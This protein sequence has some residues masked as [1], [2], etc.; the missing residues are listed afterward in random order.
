MIH[1]DWCDIAGCGV[2]RARFARGSNGAT[3]LAS[4]TDLEED[5]RL[6]FEYSRRLDELVGEL[7]LRAVACRLREPELEL[8]RFLRQ[9]VPPLALADL[10]AQLPA[11]GLGRGLQP[12]E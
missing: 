7:T 6:L 11:A 8:V 2:R 12:L 3:I 9:L 10:G 4:L 1:A 5:A